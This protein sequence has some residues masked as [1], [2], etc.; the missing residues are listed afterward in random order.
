MMKRLIF[1][2]FSLALFLEARESLFEDLATVEKIN[3]QI[4]DALPFYYNYSL[5]GGYFNMPSARMPKEGMYAIGGGNG[6]SL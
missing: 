4:N 5:I 3:Q 6:A 1:L 2:C